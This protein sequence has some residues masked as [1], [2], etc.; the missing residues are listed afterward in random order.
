MKLS[1]YANVR[2]LNNVEIREYR[3]VERW[4]INLKIR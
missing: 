1:I 2:E 3:S 4:G